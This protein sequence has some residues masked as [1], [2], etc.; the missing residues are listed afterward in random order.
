MI[1]VNFKSYEEGTGERALSLIALFEEVAREKQIKIIVALQASDIREAVAVS[2][3]EVWAQHVSSNKPGAYTGAVT[4]EAVK[5]DG[6]MGTFLNHSERRF[7]DF[8]ELAAAN[9][10]ALDLGLKTLI[11]AGS[12]KELGQAAGLSPTYLAYEPPELV[13]SKETSVA[14]AVPEIIKEAQEIAQ[15]ARIPL[16]VGAG[17]KT[18]EDVR[19]SLRLGAVGVAVASDVVIS[20]DPKGEL[21]DL[22][23]G[24]R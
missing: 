4:V 20:D 18:A 3:L 15:K 10:R 16:V 7:G 21:E 13:G 1:F 22:A 6:A 2:S 8:E 23:E 5:E 12:T 9:G 17:I 11:F 14:E 24:F 19:T